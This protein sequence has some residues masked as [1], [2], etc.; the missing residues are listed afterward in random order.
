M[1]SCT[2]EHPVDAVRL[3][4]EDRVGALRREQ[5]HAAGLAPAGDDRLDGGHRAGIALAVG[6]GDLGAPPPFVVRH[7]GVERRV[8]EG[9]DHELGDLPL[10]GGDVDGRGR[11]DVGH[12]VV[13][14]RREAD[15]EVGIERLGHLAGEPAADAL[16]GDAADDLADEEALCHRVVPRAVAG[17][18]PG[19]LGGQPG[20]A[21]LPVG[22]VLGGQRLLP[23]AQAGGVSHD[24]AHLHPLLAVGRELRPVGGDGRVEVELTA[25]VQHR[26]RRGRSSSS[27]WTRRW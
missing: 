9:L 3:H 1:R 20:R 16:A 13:L 2:P 15:V 24:V 27:W 18:P 14:A 8:H 25:V 12:A 21:E 7:G 19:R 23:A 11:D 6:G 4:L 22:Q 5:A 17:L 26:A 10:H